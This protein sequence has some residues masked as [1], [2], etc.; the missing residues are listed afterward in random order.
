MSTDRFTIEYTTTSGFDLDI[1]PF[2]PY[3]VDLIEDVYPVREY[4]KRIIELLAG[5]VVTEEYEPSEDKPDED[6]ED[7]HLWLKWYEVEDYNNKL[8]PVRIRVRRDMLLSLCVTIKDGPED[9]SDSAWIE[10]IEIPFG[11][12]YHVSDEPGQRLLT[13]IKY[14]VLTHSEDTDSVLEQAMFPEVT[15]QGVGRALQGF[16][17]DLGQF[18]AN[19]DTRKRQ[20][21]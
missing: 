20:Q 18:T 6:D 9:V 4:P 19:G 17:G 7:Y 2:P 21:K 16:R 13:F 12:D 11:G 5:D 10:R 14:V 1:T 8:E 15:L 3:Y